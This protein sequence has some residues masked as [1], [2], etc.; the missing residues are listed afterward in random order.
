MIL[1]TMMPHELIYPNDEYDFG[2]QM[3]ITHDGIPLMVERTEDADYRII[4]ILSSNPAHYLDSRYMP[5]AK[6]SIH[7]SQLQ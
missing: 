1:Y 5:G 7:S 3:E 2:K 6:I 4:R